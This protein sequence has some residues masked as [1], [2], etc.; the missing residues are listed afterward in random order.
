MR[1]RARPGRVVLP[2]AVAVRHPGHRN[3]PGSRVDARLEVFD[4]RTALLLRNNA[5]L[6]APFPLELAVEDEGGR[7][8]ELVHNDVVAGV[9]VETA[10]DDVLSVARRVEKSHLL[11]LCAEELGKPGARH[12]LLLHSTAT[13]LTTFEIGPIQAVL[14]NVRFRVAEERR[15]GCTSCDPPRNNPHRGRWLVT[16]SRYVGSNPR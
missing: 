16:R 14:R 9:E 2:K 7:K 6:D 8:V 10:G 11:R 4:A 12:L 13:S 3:E 15:D 1:E 5:E